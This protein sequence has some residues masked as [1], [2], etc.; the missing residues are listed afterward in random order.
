MFE[1]TGKARLAE[2][3]AGIGPSYHL[4]VEHH[5]RA[6]NLRTTSSLAAQAHVAGPAVHPYT[7][8]MD[9]GQFSGFAGSF[10]EL[11]EIH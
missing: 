1:D 11:L 7:F 8:R 6:E 10:E 2:Y 9:S 3:A 5:S 4:V